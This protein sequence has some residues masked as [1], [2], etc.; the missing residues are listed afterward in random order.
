[1]RYRLMSMILLWALSDATSQAS[2]LIET[3]RVAPH[4][5]AR[6]ELDI[7]ID[8]GKEPGFVWFEVT[9]GPGMGAISADCRGQL[10]VGSGRNLF[11]DN[12][13]FIQVK[14]R[15]SGDVLRY[16]FG[17]DTEMIANSYFLFRN[18]ILNERGHHESYEI[19]LSGFVR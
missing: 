8:V 1:M 9:V 2:T 19:E 14:P 4:N 5:I 13:A 16:R 12:L 3:H 7:R 10:A 15:C 6:Q 17:L 18:P 11:I